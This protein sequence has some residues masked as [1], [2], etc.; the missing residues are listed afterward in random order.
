MVKIYDL[1]SFPNFFLATFKD[2]NK[3]IWYRFEIS[4]RKN[5]SNKLK[6]FLLQD[7]LKLIG[8]NSINYDYPLL[9]NTILSNNINWTAE[10]I[11][12][13]SQ[14]I[15]NAEYSAIWDNKIKVPQLDLFKI[16]HYDNKNKS[17]SLKWLEF[18]MRM[19]NVEDLPYHF[20][21]VLTYEEMD[22]VI[23]YC[24]N[25]L[26]ATEMFFNK[27]IK[28]IKIRDFYSKKENLNLI[29]A[30]ETKMAKEIFGK[31][32]SKEMGIETKE[33]KKLRTI[34]SRVEL[35]NVMF[36]YIQFNDSINVQTLNKFKNFT[37][38]EYNELKF[39][40]QY[41][42]VKREY[43]EGGLHSFG[44]PGVYETDDSYL[45]VDVDFASFYPF[46]TFKNNLH[47]RHI[48]EKV[49]NE[50]YEGFY[51]ERK[52]YPKTDPINYVLK[53]LLNSSYGLSKD[54]YAFLYDVAWQLSV[55][56]NGQLILTLLTE[57]IFEKISK[58][59]IIFENTDGAAY[60]I[61]KDEL[62]LLKEACV[63]IEKKVNI[64][65]EIQICKKM[66]MKD[67]N[68]YINIINDDV[69]KFKGAYE[70]DRDFHK[71]HS[72]RIVAIAAVNYFIYDVEPEITLKNHLTGVQ[73]DFAE[74]YGI[75]DFCIGSKMKGDNKLY[76][77]E[78]K[79]TVITNKALSKVTRYY[80]SK[81]GNQLIKILPP[82]EKNFKTETD[83]FKEKHPNQT[84]MFDFIEDVKVDPKD[85]ETNIE[86]GSLCTVFNKFKI[87][88]NYNLSY[89]YYLKEINKL[90]NV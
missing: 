51:Q 34:R 18:A 49:F 54:K 27:S 79:G 83:K 16:W 28:H 10:K 36:D 78:T 15:I 47:P 3:E 45:I 63:E 71:N 29:N 9:H 72:K 39:S 22:H 6:Q 46:I 67:V 87:K 37:K 89:N 53:I 33:L 13:E 41:K 4:E 50:L 61:K 55:V 84:N 32:L 40:T 64:P 31:Y 88:E 56:I 74:N 17:C 62:H 24:D 5:E 90:I 68:N 65:L 21:K 19:E 81:Q 48:P 75:Y 26:L 80:V 57:R 59:L 44:K 42:N 52:K 70:I 43:G 66:I 2:V 38:T 11:N 14:N 76:E 60:R 20:T 58:G 35:K 7:K 85:R 73:Y 69:V 86:A 1:E 30:S 12:S 23:A 25:D 8:F 77:R 82:L